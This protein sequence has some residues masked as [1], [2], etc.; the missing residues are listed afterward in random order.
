MHL[1]E[2]MMYRLHGVYDWGSL[3]IHLALEEIGAPFEFV[4]LDPAQGDLSSPSYLALNPFGLVPV[5]ET[6][7]GPLFETA[8]ILLYLADRHNAL[9]PAPSAPDRGAFLVWLAVVC[10]QLHPAVLQL[11]H[12]ERLLGEEAQRAVAD[13]THRRLLDIC[14]KLDGRAQQGDWWFS[15]APTSAPTSILT[16]YIAMLLRWAQAL[17]PYREHALSL[18]DFP[19]LLAMIQALETRAPIARALAREGLF[20][21]TATPLSAP[22]YEGS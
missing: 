7:D 6:P 2:G 16:L 22:I 8:A 21:V 3:V 17:P 4:M 20:A 12:P 18:A 5:L 15:A 11:I 1:W 9:A 14:A 13:A 19:A 10:Q